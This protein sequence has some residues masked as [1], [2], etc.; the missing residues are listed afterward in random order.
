LANRNRCTVTMFALND[1]LSDRAATLT[2]IASALSFRAQETLMRS[3]TTK[4]VRLVIEWSRT[5]AE[6]R[7]PIDD[8][9]G[10]LGRSVGSVQQLLRRVLPRANGRGLSGPGGVPKRSRRPKG[11]E[12]RY[13]RERQRP[14]RST[15]VA[16]GVV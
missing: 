11:T 7:T 14:S 2:S 15:S 4:E 6:A 13:H 10:Q 12:Q 1:S 16:I 8:I 5:P 9:A 3:W